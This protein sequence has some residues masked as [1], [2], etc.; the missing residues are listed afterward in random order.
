MLLLVDI[1]TRLVYGMLIWLGIRRDVNG[2]ADPAFL[3]IGG[4]VWFGIGFS[5]TGL[6]LVLLRRLESGRGQA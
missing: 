2:P 3:A 4:V 6:V 1:P 5:V